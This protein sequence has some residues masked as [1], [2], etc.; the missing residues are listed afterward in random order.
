M[1][2]VTGREDDM[3]IFVHKYIKNNKLI[4]SASSLDLALDIFLDKL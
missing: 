2:V 4:E 1:E 3:K